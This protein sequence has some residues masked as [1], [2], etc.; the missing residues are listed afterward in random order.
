MIDEKLKSLALTLIVGAAGAAVAV[1][2]SFPAPFLLGPALAVTLAGLGGM[3]LH[4]PHL[5]RNMCFILV[6][7]SMGAAITPEVFEATRKWP[8]SFILLPVAIAVLLYIAFVILHRLFAYD[9]TTALLAASPGHLSYVMSLAADSRGDIMAIGV[10][11]SVRVLALTL[12]VPVIVEWLDLAGV[13]PAVVPPPLPPPVLL[14]SLA[15]SVALGLLFVKL[16][17]PAA[18]MLGGLAVSLSTHITGLTSGGLPSWMLMCAYGL[19]GC[20]IGSRFSGVSLRRLKMAFAAGAV[21]TV[22][23]V[24]VAGLFAGLVSW[25]TGVPLNAV[26][27]AFSPG[28]LETMSAMAVM[29][30]ADVA[31]V[32][33]HHVFRLIFLAGLM[34][35]VLRRSDGGAE[36]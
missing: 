29:M 2:L 3:R 23:V 16:A 4:V 18:Y 7:I 9:R 28:G 19:L 11:Q 32:G 35:A 26:M 36:R 34:P 33:S 10:I 27:I 1:A 22:A 8:L 21:V 25:A 24:A 31:Y 17:L 30:H 14:L 15:A 12:A 5:L 13:A 6:G 20:L